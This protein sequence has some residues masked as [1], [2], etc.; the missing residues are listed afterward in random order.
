VLAVAFQRQIHGL[1]TRDLV[2]P[3]FKIVAAS[4]VMAAAIWLVSSRL[5]LVPH[6]GTVMFA[7]KAFV[8]IA[9]GAA[10]YFAAARA[11]GVDEARALLSRFRR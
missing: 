1:F 3:F 2:V 11:L 6:A 5:E 9:I 7:I 4:L 10:V 8:P